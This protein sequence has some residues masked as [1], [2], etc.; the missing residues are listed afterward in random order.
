MAPLLL[1]MTLL[2]VSTCG[3]FVSANSLRV[4]RSFAARAGALRA[5]SA[6]T[7][8]PDTAPLASLP[9]PVAK[10]LARALG[11]RAAPRRVRL[12]HHGKMRLAP[13]KGWVAIRGTQEFSTDPPG[14][15]WWGRVRVAPGVWVDAV[16]HLVDGTA[17]MRILFES[18]FVLGD[19][20]GHELDQGA[21]LR[22]LGEM[23]WFPTAYLD[24]RYVT[25]TPIDDVTARATLRLRGIEVSAVF[26]FGA[27]GLPE[28]VSANR[29]RD[30]DGKAEL[31]G[32]SGQ[33]S[34]YRRVN[35]VLVPFTMEA[36]WHLDDGPFTCLRFE[37]DSLELD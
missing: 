16:D 3:V 11:D 24:R 32:W 28:R 20:K 12:T 21:A 35:G 36:T 17:G 29:Y 22:V 7:S 37:L 34:D 31:T 13:E 30:V 26:Q 15:V 1:W 9:R 5:V 19:S 33:A 4:K 6:A 8:A 23:A 10:Y 18:S 25:W 27:D 2:V 14:F